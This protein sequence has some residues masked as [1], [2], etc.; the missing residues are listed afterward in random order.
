MLL[1]QLA[2]TNASCLLRQ[3]ISTNLMI[4][5]Q[6]RGLLVTT[7]GTP[8]PH[9]LKFLPGRP[10][11][12]DPDQT[13]DISAA[14]YATISPLA[15]QL[16]EVDGVTRVFYGKDFVAVTKEENLDWN[17]LKSEIMGLISDNFEQ[18]IQLFTEDFE[19][20]DDESLKIMDTDSEALAMVKEIF[21]ARI[22]P[23]V[24]EDGGDIVLLEFNEETGVVYV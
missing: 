13:M 1:R 4:Q 10:V 14:K 12:G 21:T 9:S 15:V 5:M 7:A 24:Q 20:E 18:K 3:R 17:D 22:K 16:F 2:K 8:N 23:F 19:G 11:T 6:M